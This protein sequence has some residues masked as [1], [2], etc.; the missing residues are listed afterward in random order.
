MVGK[1]KGKAAEQGACECCKRR[2]IKCVPPTEGK[3]T[4]LCGV[5]IGKGKVHA[6]W[7]GVSGAEGDVLEEAH[8]GQIATG[9]EETGMH[10]RIRGHQGVGGDKEVSKVRRGCGEGGCGGGAIWEWWGAHTPHPESVSS[11]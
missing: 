9:K 7:R 10:G 5:S 11:S 3:A 2:G 1:G 6:T 8:G 4:N